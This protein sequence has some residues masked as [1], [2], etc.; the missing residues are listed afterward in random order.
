MITNH[1]PEEYQKQWHAEL[2]RNLDE[3]IKY[4]EHCGFSVIVNLAT[5]YGGRE[6]IKLTNLDSL[7]IEKNAI[8]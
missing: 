5:E 6:S 2:Q 4:L 3:H 7:K 1:I 8:S